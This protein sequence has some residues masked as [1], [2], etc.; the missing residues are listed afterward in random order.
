MLGSCSGYKWLTAGYGVGFLYVNRRHLHPEAFPAAGWRSAR[1]PYDMLSDRLDL[2][3]NAAALELGHPPFA[4]VFAL[5]AALELFE[6]IGPEAVERRVFDLSAYGAERIGALGHRVVTPTDEAHR[7]GITS[8]R[9][10]SPAELKRTLA[11]DLGIHVSARGDVLRVSTHLF[12]DESDV[13]R[14]AA[15]LQRLR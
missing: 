4:S 15:A 5:G 14:L 11:E 10:E 1:I 3:D 9:I 13:D 6:A 12:N 2:S 8:V 7:A